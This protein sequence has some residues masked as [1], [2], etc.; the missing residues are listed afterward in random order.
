MAID[1]SKL[2]PE[3]QALLR[4]NNPAL[5][6][7]NISSLGSTAQSIG[8]KD[9]SQISKNELIDAYASAGNKNAQNIKANNYT[10]PPLSSVKDDRTLPNPVV[11]NKSLPGARKSSL[12]EFADT[13][14]KATSLARQS[15]QAAQMGILDTAG[16]Q[17]GSVAPATMAGILKLMEARSDDYSNPLTSA[18]QDAYRDEIERADEEIKQ[19]DEEARQVQDLAISLL[20]K[21]LGNETIQG[22]L[23][24]PD[25]NSAIAVASAALKT[26]SKN[27]YVDIRSSGNSIVGIKDDGTAEVIYREPKS[28]GGGSSPASKPYTSGGLVITKADIGDISA[29][30]EGSRGQD[31]YTDP[32]LYLKALS[33]WTGNDGLADDFY[34]QFSPSSYLNPAVDASVLGRPIPAPIT[35]ELK[36]TYKTTSSNPFL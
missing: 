16:F 12:V 15:R 5:Y 26:S 1:L 36:K 21:G 29:Q 6:N 27:P 20:T 4:Q 14:T 35:N 3:Q 10:L 22:V 17:P 32:N 28:T 19:K 34:K 31:G 23:A 24:A 9:I 33:I 2:T 8:N 13:L 25:M 30:L 11:E 18:A 7:A